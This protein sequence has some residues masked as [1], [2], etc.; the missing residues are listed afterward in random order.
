M[1]TLIFKLVII[2][3]IIA[4]IIKYF[5][6]HKKL[7]RIITPSNTLLVSLLN[8]GGIAPVAG[9]ISLNNHSFLL[10]ILFSLVITILQIILG[11]IFGR[12]KEERTTWSIINFYKNTGLATVITLASFG[13]EALLGVVAY[14][15]VT[16]AVLA[17][18]QLFINKN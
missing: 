7:E 13:T 14:I 9:L 16:N 10:A 15:I 5:G 17:P 11:F 6:W 12:N 3:L 8:W 4:E 2:P 1:F 18:F